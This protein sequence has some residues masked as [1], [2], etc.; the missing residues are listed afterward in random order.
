MGEDYSGD[1]V[2]METNKK[3][4][5]VAAECEGDL[6]QRRERKDTKDNILKIMIPK[7]ITRKGVG[8]GGDCPEG[9]VT[10]LKRRVKKR[11]NKVPHSSEEAV[12]DQT[13][14]V[15]ETDTTL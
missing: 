11:N 1:S 15:K 3:K 5:S 9:A 14:I 6:E 2:E 12:E 10:S 8:E 4:R 7:T 13:K